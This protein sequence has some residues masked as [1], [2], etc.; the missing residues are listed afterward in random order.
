MSAPHSVGPPWLHSI[1]PVPS[2]GQVPASAIFP[3]LPGC[4]R[5]YAPMWRDTQ[6][7]MQRPP[8]AKGVYDL[9]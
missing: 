9:Y 4:G 7:T 1:Y 2:Y 8:N 6:G 5:I 3:V